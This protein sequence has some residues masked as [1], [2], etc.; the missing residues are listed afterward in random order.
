MFE[1]TGHSCI[2]KR[3]SKSGTM[4]WT[5]FYPDAASCEVI[6]IKMIFDGSE[7]R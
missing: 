6:F 4:P 1:F 5:G 3:I 7:A 2:I